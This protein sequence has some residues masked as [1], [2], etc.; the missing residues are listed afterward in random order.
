MYVPS[1][2]TLREIRPRSAI[3]QPQNNTLNSTATGI[4]TLKIIG[5]LYEASRSCINIFSL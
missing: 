5:V 4:G 3:E 1:G 2:S